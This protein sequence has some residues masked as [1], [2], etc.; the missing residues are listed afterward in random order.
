MEYL[1]VKFCYQGFNDADEALNFLDDTDVSDSQSRAIFGD[2][3][4]D[5]II[6]R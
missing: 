3:L 4:A 5:D 6:S 2:F 1:L